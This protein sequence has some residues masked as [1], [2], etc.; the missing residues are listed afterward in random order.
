MMDEKDLQNDDDIDVSFE[1]ISD[2]AD[3]PE[4]K[5]RKLK[6]KLSDCRKEK[7]EYLLGWQRCKADFV[8][9]K[10][11]D[12]RDRL[13]LLDSLSESF[14]NELLPVLDSFDLAFADKSQVE[15]APEGWRT[16]FLSIY[17][18]LMDTLKRLGLRQIGHV[19]DKLDIK[20]EEPVA[21]VSVDKEDEDELVTEVLQFGYSLNGK[22]I[23][24]AKVKV[25]Q[26]NKSKN[27]N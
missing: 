6:Q 27:K 26:F 16:G 9:A 2:D 10:K 24:P 19:G 18:K 11:S 4:E 17:S 23:R 12:E 13:S 1:D 21:L 20:T 25:G 22:V 15:K 5:I 3:S 7:E 14:I 8:N